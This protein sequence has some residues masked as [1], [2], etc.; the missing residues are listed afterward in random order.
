MEGHHFWEQQNEIQE[1]RFLVPKDKRKME[2]PFSIPAV[3]ECGEIKFSSPVTIFTGENGSG[4]STILEAIAVAAGFNPE[5]GSKNFTFSTQNTHS[6]LYEDTQI[7][8]GPIGQRMYFLGQKAFIMWQPIL[9]EMDRTVKRGPRLVSSYG[10]KIPASAVTW[11]ILF[12]FSGKP[13]WR[14]GTV[15]L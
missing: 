13:F 7:V 2:Y 6:Q 3:R 14:S 8:R 12:I 11:G 5:G 4:K 1:V 10:G 9:I 15:Y